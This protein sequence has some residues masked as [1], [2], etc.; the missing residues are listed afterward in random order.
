MS[1]LDLVSMDTDTIVAVD[2]HEVENLA[3]ELLKIWGL[4]LDRFYFLILNLN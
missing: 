3:F 1:A 2:F 4:F